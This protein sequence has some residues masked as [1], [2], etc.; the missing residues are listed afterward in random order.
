MNNKEN[1][2]KEQF[3]QALISTAKAISDDYNLDKKNT[4]CIFITQ[5]KQTYEYFLS[6]GFIVFL[7][8]KLFERKQWYA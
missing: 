2:L 6:E 5:F 3:K 7:I 4:S 1:N 8:K